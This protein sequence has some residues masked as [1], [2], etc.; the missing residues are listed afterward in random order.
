MNWALAV[1]LGL[2]A[3]C[4]GSP[5]SPRV[6]V[7]K[8]WTLAP[9][10]VTALRADDPNRDSRALWDRFGCAELRELLA[11]ASHHS[12]DNAS[13]A[14]RS[15]QQEALL[16]V[17]RAPL[18]PSLAVTA[19]LTGQSD[20][21]RNLRSI[22]GGFLDV[23]LVASYDVDV[24]GENRQR[25]S[26][27]KA[28]G[29]ASRFERASTQLTVAAGV[30]ATYFEILSLRE[31]TARGKANLDATRRVLAV[32]E[33]KARA[34]AALAREVS[35]QTA[36]VA[37]EA[38]LVEQLT[39]AEAEA[40]I[41][42]AL[43]L[44]REPNEIAVRAESLDAVLDPSIG[45]VDIDLPERLLRRRPDV[46]RA[47][48]E[49]AASHADVQAARAALL[50][51][52]RLVAAAGLQSV[53][54]SN[55]DDGAALVYTGVA[56]LNAPIFDGGALSGERDLA[57][58]R[59][60]EAEADYRRVVIDA[61]AEVERALRSLD[62]LQKQYEQQRIVVDEARRAFELLEVEY[63]AGAEELLAVLDAQR[64]LFRA[65]DDFSQMRLAKLRTG[66]L[67]VKALG[68]GWSKAK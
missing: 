44:G 57:A 35:Q 21:G 10:S 55:Y 49:L 27:S 14:A 24:W 20:N 23:G 22:R 51:Q 28:R 5:P 48:A 32:V 19:D 13:A 38:I 12:L 40:S 1:G 7:A 37:S 3:G 2:L 65:E 33:A 29:D 50:P 36:L 4:A 31:R 30:A 67:L 58:A 64:T 41:S 39:V 52:L 63:K 8:R 53:F 45:M 18:Y 17:A 43:A 68:G 15:A 26:A 9:A 42:L 60:A 47:E 46:A 61:V 66:V 34:G 62:G 54:L 11:D 16:R 56:S 25:A 6:I 59:R